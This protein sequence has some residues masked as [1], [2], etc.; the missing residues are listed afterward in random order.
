MQQPELDTAHSPAA[1][2]PPAPELPPPP[3]FP[4][5]R[6]QLSL[7]RTASRSRTPAHDQEGTPC[8]MKAPP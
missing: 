6:E 2:A 7:R 3:L 5:P 8:I 1:S 4:L